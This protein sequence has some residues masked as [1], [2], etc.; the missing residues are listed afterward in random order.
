MTNNRETRTGEHFDF[1][2]TYRVVQDADRVQSVAASHGMSGK[3]KSLVVGNDEVWGS[4][5]KT[6]RLGT[7]LV[8]LQ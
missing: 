2:N 5:A 3:F 8:R 4:P 6:P 1:D 7:K